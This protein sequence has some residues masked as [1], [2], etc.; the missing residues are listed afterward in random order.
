[1]DTFSHLVFITANQDHYYV[2]ILKFKKTRPREVNRLTDS[3]LWSQNLFPDPSEHKS[4][5]FN[6]RT[7]F[8]SFLMN[9]YYFFIIR[10]LFFVVKMDCK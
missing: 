3:H 10:K 7:A 1:M 4:A 5:V 2:I 8:P 9:I 6:H